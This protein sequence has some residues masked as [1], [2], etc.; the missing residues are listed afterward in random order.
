MAES[1]IVKWSVAIAQNVLGTLATAVVVA[2]GGL[3][4][5][6]LAKATPLVAK[7]APLSYFVTFLVAVILLLTLANLGA[8][9]LHRFRGPLRPSG[10]NVSPSDNTAAFVDLQDHVSKM[11]TVLS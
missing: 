10:A 3:L 2:V 5:V 4:A 6:L 11:A 9:L 7:F 8:A 1:N